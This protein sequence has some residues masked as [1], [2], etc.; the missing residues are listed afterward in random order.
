M[1]AAFFPPPEPLVA[2]AARNGAVCDTPPSGERILSTTP[3]HG[4]RLDSIDSY[5]LQQV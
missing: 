5:Y 4:T 2:L 1:T 3:Q